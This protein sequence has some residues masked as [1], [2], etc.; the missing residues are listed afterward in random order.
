M[1]MKFIIFMQVLT[2]LMHMNSLKFFYART[3]MEYLHLEA[4]HKNGEYRQMPLR[5]NKWL[6]KLASVDIQM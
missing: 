2:T 3:L 5:S 6:I 4:A 1:Y